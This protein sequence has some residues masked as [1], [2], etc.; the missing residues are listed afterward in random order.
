MMNKEENG[1]TIVRSGVLMGFLDG[2]GDRAGFSVCDV[3]KVVW[4]KKVERDWVL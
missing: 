4:M 2:D 3:E 1:R